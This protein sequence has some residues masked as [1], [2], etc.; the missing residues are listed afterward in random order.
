MLASM[1]TVSDE[2]PGLESGLRR[3]CMSAGEKIHHFMIS[4]TDGRDSGLLLVSH[5]SLLTGMAV[6]VWLSTLSP[7]ADESRAGLPGITSMLR[8][9]PLPALA[10]IMAL[11]VADTAASAIGKRWGRHKICQGTKKTMEGTFGAVACTMLSWAA[12]DTIL[13]VCSSQSLPVL[14]S[15]MWA[16]LLVSSM[17]SCILEA[18]TT[19]LD[20]IF[21]P[22]HYMAMLSV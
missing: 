1:L 11:G 14:H 8:G 19:Q 16:S 18:S 7:A 13:A 20:N 12:L 15:P 17:L 22:I 9:V 6:P 4:F 3:S 10:G 2:L 21:I 5:F